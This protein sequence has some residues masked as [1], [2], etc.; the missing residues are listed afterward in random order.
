MLQGSCVS[1]SAAP[2]R[3]T[4]APVATLNAAP[5][6]AQI[7]HKTY[8]ELHFCNVCLITKDVEE[9]LYLPNKCLQVSIE[10]QE[11]AATLG[12]NGSRWLQ[13]TN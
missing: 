3:F 2:C 7:C 13:H 8:L 11:V 5:M 9:V 6:C 4:I 12:T 10:Q 1:T